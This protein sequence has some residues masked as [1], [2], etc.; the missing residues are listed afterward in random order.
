M[1]NFIEGA[2]YLAVESGFYNFLVTFRSNS[3][4]NNKLTD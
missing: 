3:V 2:Y 4:S 1:S